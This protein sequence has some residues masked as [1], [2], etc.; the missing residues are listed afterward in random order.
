[1][2]RLRDEP[3]EVTGEFRKLLAAGDAEERARAQRLTAAVGIVCSLLDFDE[4]DHWELADALEP[5]LAS[6]EYLLWLQKANLVCLTKSDRVTAVEARRR[7]IG[8]N[9]YLL[10]PHSVLLHNEEV[11]RTAAT[12]AGRI[13]GG[14]RRRALEN[15]R[16]EVAGKLRNDLLPN[17]F[18]YRTE[19]MIFEAGERD[20][21]LRDRT[22]ALE[23]QLTQLDGEIAARVNEAQAR[24][25]RALAVIF[26]LLSATALGDL[27]VL[28][29][30]D[31]PRWHLAAHLGSF[32]AVFLVIVVVWLAVW[33]RSRR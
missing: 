33:R 23:R 29:F 15:I 32:A 3:D 14:E 17:V 24:E 22:G 5:G 25:E 4:I 7:D 30:S 31:A 19:R 8:T 2:S 6:P 9:P 20:R 16:R 1:M 18:H 26:G 10:A 21:G 27:A 13:Q 28:A 12:A 11:L